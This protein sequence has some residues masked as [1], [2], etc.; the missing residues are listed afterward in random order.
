MAAVIETVP[1]VGVRIRYLGPTNHAGSRFRVWRADGSYGEDPNRVTVSYDYGA[2]HPEETAL[3][4][5]LQRAGW[6]GRWMI[7]CAGSCDRVAVRV[8]DE[9]GHWEGEG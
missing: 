4:E 5:Y 3:R 9:L 6:D 1:I 7:A 8:A 2:R